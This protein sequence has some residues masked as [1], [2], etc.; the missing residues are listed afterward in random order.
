MF[1]VYYTVVNLFLVGL[2]ELVDYVFLR[3]INL[4]LSEGNN[5]ALMGLLNFVIFKN[6]KFITDC[7][8]RVNGLLHLCQWLINLSLSYPTKCS[9]LQ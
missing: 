2:N 6:D 9:F 4:P 1:L 8:E 3:V 5:Q 7:M